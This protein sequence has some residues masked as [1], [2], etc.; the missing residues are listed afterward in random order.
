MTS[1]SAK[2]TPAASRNQLADIVVLNMNVILLGL[3]APKYPRGCILRSHVS[4][5]A[6]K[7]AAGG[8][9]F[10]AQELRMLP[11]RDT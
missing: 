3:T 11:E 9:F 7:P 10:F 4:P 5:D 2:A 1:S 8:A 6:V